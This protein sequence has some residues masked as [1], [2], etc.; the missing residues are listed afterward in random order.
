MDTLRRESGPQRGASREGNQDLEK[1]GP[2]GVVRSSEKR[3]TLRRGVRH[4]MRLKE[5]SR[6][7]RARARGTSG[8]KR[9]SKSET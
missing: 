6:A 5:G 2:Q 1:G 3:G 7:L 8:I 4:T 9:T